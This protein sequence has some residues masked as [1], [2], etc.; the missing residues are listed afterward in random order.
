M[1][2]RIRA[3]DYRLRVSKECLRMEETMGRLLLAATLAFVATDAFVVA[4]LDG[5]AF[6]QSGYCPAGTCAKNG[7]NFATDVKNCSAANC[8]GGGTATTTEPKK[9]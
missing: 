4:P 5:G 2:M 9:K 7:S 3:Q 8:F 1:G 6:A